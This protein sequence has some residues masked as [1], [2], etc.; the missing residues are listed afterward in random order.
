[1]AAKRK[2]SDR[3]GNDIKLGD[4]KPYRVGF[5]RPPLKTRF[6]PNQSGNPKG[7]PRRHSLEFSHE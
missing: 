6:K 1:M 2:S 4:G 3:R 7:R 5:G